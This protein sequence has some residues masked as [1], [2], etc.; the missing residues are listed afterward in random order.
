[1]ALCLGS[2]WVIQHLICWASG[3]KSLVFLYSPCSSPNQRTSLQIPT[4][5]HRTIPTRT[6]DNTRDSGF[7][8]ENLK[9]L[10][11]LAW[12]DYV[13]IRSIHSQYP[14]EA[15]SQALLTTVSPILHFWPSTNNIYRYSGLVRLKSATAS[16]SNARR[17]LTAFATIFHNA[18]SR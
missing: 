12:V 18:A 15:T 8:I 14:I 16:S 10:L 3:V 9:L 2:S 11:K 5:N 17:P 13:G 1:M 4:K 6:M 7:A